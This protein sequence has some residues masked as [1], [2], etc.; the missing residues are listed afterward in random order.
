MLCPSNYL[1]LNCYRIMRM[2]KKLYCRPFSE[3][4]SPTSNPYPYPYP[5]PLQTLPTTSDSVLLIQL[6]LLCKMIIVLDEETISYTCAR[7]VV[8]QRHSPNTPLATSQSRT[9]P[10]CS[11]VSGSK[12]A[13]TRPAPAEDTVQSSVGSPNRQRCDTHAHTPCTDPPGS[14][15]EQLASLPC[16]PHTTTRTLTQTG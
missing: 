8:F 2:K 13:P 1:Y 11:G 12:H 14:E 6:V 9:W 4:H 5:Y 10:S 3:H 15:W 16:H 7:S